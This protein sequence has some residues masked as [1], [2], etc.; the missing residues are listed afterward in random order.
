MT[1]TGPQGPGIRTSAPAAQPSGAEDLRLPKPPGFV[2][3]FFNRHP[4][5]LDGLIAGTYAVPMGLFALV[6]AVSVLFGR[7]F[8]DDPVS[9]SPLYPALLLYGAAAVSVALLF[10][11]HVPVITAA[12][13]IAAMLLPSSNGPQL[14]VA[15]VLFALY[16]L[17]VYR[18][19]R[20]AWIGT[21]AAA[22]VG[23]LATALQTGDAV[24]TV[25]FG[26]L[27]AFLVV[28]ATLVGITF[29]NRR[30]Y[31]D[32]LLERAAQLARER[33]QRA[34]LAVASERARIAREMHDIVAHSLTVIV[35]LSDGAEASL[36]R[37][38]TAPAS[39]QEAV[40]QTGA[41][42]RRALTDMRRSLGVLA[43]DDAAG[44]T[45]AAPLALAPQPGVADLPELIATFRAA[46]LPVRFTS[47]GEPPADTVLQLTVYRIVQESLTNALR[48]ARGVDRVDVELRYDSAGVSIAV[49]DDGLDPARGA[50]SEGSGRGLIG[51]RERVQVHGGQ[52]SAGPLGT[53]GWRVAVRLGDPPPAARP[54]PDTP[55]P[56]GTAPDGPAPDA[57][58]TT[59]PQE[60]SP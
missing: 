14:D 24:Q 6:V 30:R 28:I 31:I 25:A 55:A 26:L 60:G 5:L 49:V 47:V 16:A 37:S 9:S 29:G 21:A 7:V 42:A 43:D 8:G 35:A 20:A 40:R 15:P 27:I 13:C 17:A 3:S 48:Y 41:T 10:R 44:V 2:R 33:D 56:D 50:A 52:V 46:G 32:A 54:T 11:R 23:V 4:W 22:G 51:L 38:G 39:A 59:P 58:P 45:D 57:A 1:T 34:Q 19:V 36:A 53:R 18:S 12:I